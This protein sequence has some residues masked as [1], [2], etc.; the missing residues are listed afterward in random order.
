MN[1]D[2]ITYE[3]TPANE[4]KIGWS[5]VPEYCRGDENASHVTHNHI[6]GIFLFHNDDDN[7]EVMEGQ[8]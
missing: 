1:N 5:L 6:Q 3:N 8:A 7:E 2:F 4:T